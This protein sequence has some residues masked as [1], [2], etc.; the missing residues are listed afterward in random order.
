VL[1]LWLPAALGAQTRQ[2]S[3]S[4]LNGLKAR[5]GIEV[6]ETSMKRHTGEFVTV[7]DEGLTLKEKGSNISLKRENVA[8][9]SRSSGRKRG[10]HALIWGVAGG[11]VG[12]GIG[13]AVGSSNSFWNANGKGTS[14]GALVGVAI[15]APSGALVGAMLPD[16]TTVYRAAPGAAAR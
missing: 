15:F 13:A 1:L 6:I 11:L 10:E 16:N 5:Q 9:V 8:R 4:N 14:T 2:G 7:N 12:A 3:W